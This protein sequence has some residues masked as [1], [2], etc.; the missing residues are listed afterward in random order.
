MGGNW[1]A[2]GFGVWGG[3]LAPFGGRDAVKWRK[4][5]RDAWSDRLFHV[6]RMGHIA[7]L[8]PLGFLCVISPAVTRT[9]GV[10]V[11]TR[12]MVGLCSGVRTIQ[13]AWRFPFGEL[14]GGRRFL[15]PR[16]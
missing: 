6:R 9:F 3:D 10:S 15:E 5:R 14:E 2:S 16:A 8:G 13:V 1:R 11:V 4:W 12:A 7:A